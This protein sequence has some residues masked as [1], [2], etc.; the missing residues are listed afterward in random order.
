MS[1]L[2]TLGL[3]DAGPHIEIRT[4]KRSE[5]LVG[6]PL[7]VGEGGRPQFSDAGRPSLAANGGVRT[8]QTGENL[9]TTA[10]VSESPRAPQPLPEVPSPV[11][12]AAPEPPPFQ[13]VA[14]PEQRVFTPPSAAYQAASNGASGAA[15]NGSYAP[16][17][18][19]YRAPAAPPQLPAPPAPEST[20][21]QR[22]VRALRSAVPYV[23]KILPLL[24]GNFATALANILGP[25]QHQHAAPPP[26]QPP[27]NLEPITLSLNELRNQQRDLRVQIV[28]QNS[29]LKRVED[30]LEMVREATDRNTLEQQELIEDLKAVGNK[31]NMFALIA[32]G[33]LTASI[34]LNI[35]LYLRLHHA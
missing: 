1:N 34:L 7:P 13:P 30:Q 18:A 4:E 25:H 31:V 8:Q 32:V 15:S 24:D 14:E 21:M 10:P 17:D 27:V 26:P 28:D 20:G 12:A 5:R 33:L 16:S 11:V 6:L 3:A 19:P 29:S 23:Q 35:V 9:R 22:A 2:E